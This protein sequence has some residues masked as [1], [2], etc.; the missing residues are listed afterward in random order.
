MSRQSTQITDWSERSCDAGQSRACSSVRVAVVDDDPALHA[1]VREQLQ[2]A[3][4]SWQVV[5]YHN[6]AD[7]L[8]G[9]AA[10]PPQVGFI[11]ADDHLRE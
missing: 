6:G 1:Q 7:A 4:E 9:V 3:G 8:I 5:T 2:Q 11:L 10:V